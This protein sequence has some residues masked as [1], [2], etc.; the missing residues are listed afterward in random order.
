MTYLLDSNVLIAL[1]IAEHEHHDRAAAWFGEDDRDFA[2]CPTVQGSLVRFVIRMGESAATAAAL[3]QAMSAHERVTF[4]PDGVSYT[5]VSLSDLT[6]HRQVTDT[7]LAAIAVAHEGLLATF[8]T[9]LLA[10][11]PESTYRVP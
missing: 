8:D 5:D 10:L 1:A 9:S 6:G 11:R 2:V 4:W 7:Y 3:V